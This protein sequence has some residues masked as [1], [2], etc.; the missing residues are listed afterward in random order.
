MNVKSM[1]I[2][3]LPLAL[4]AVVSLGAPLS[5]VAIA[6]PVKSGGTSSGGSCT[7]TAGSNAGKTGTYTTEEGTGHT[8]CE[9][10]WGGTDCTG[11]RCKDGARQL[12]TVSGAL[13]VLRSGS[14]NFMR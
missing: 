3:A 1:S 10:S 5:N 11:G 2:R 13:P 12:G 6:A 4:A 7:V 8:W 14:F 9:G